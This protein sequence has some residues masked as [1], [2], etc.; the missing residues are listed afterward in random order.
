[1]PEHSE[2][3]LLQG[4]YATALQ[5]LLGLVSMSALLYKRY[6][7]E[8]DRPRSAD[9]WLMD[10]SKQGVQS[11]FLHFT[12]MFSS[13]L[14][15]QFQ[16]R[17]DHNSSPETSS[18]THD[19]CAF[20]FITFVLD[21]FLGIHLIWLVLRG[22]R[23]LAVTCGWLS[24]R[25][26]GYY[27]SPASFAWYLKQ[28]YVFLFATAVSKLIIGALMLSTKDWLDLLG[29]WLFSRFHLHP[30]AE[31]TVVMVIAPVVLSSIQYWLLDNMLM[32]P[33]TLHHTYSSLDLIDKLEEEGGENNS[34]SLTPSGKGD[35]VFHRARTNS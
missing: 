34:S 20:Y 30:A 22:I 11:V 4:S 3:R 23:G 33:S 19:E 25:D 27:G 14:F 21:T 17:N 26:Q 15:A 9:V 8:A 29:T 32:M 18:Y 31:L 1:M 28:L 6:V 24:I 2:C 5:L 7:V 10:V 12:N 16:S 13:I 35:G